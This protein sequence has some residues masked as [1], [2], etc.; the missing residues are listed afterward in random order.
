MDMQDGTAGPIMLMFVT[1]LGAAWMIYSTLFNQGVLTFVILLA[2]I[3][4]ASTASLL[5]YRKLK[6][7]HMASAQNSN[8]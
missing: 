7:C 8:N 1:G 3:P 2:Y 5:L 6:R 4:A